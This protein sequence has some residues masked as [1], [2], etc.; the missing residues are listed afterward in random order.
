MATNVF[1]FVPA[2]GQQL[3]AATVMTVQNVQQAFM[4]KGI[5]GGFS[6]LSFP[7]IA[8]LRSMVL[9]MWYDAMPM[10][11]HLL[12][13]DADMGFAP[14]LPLDMLLF[15]HPL[16]GALYPQRKIP[17]S[18]A[19][20]GTGK[21]IA[22]RRGDFM[23]VEGTGM[24]CTLIR[25]DCVDAIIANEERSAAQRVDAIIGEKAND[26]RDAGVYDKVR[27]IIRSSFPPFI[28]YR[29]EM[30]PGKELMANAGAK[31]IIRAFDGLDIP[32]RGRVSEDLSF[33][34]RAADAGIPCWAAIG[35]RLS[36]VGMYDYGACYLE[37]IAAPQPMLT[38]AKW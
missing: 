26:L 27:A 36:H 19:G 8:E 7:D 37:S 38:T 10:S 28:D 15:D 12:F 22:E 16:V 13:I 14:T 18:W 23:R 17:L 31:R 1:I 11:S 34:I 3:S 29:M 2:F 35:H 21:P 5:G 20:S 30:H 4:A 24:G 25:R 6:S 33:C 9:T 32:A